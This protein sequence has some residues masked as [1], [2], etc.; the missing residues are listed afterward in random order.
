MGTHMKTTVEISDALLDA[1]KATAARRGTTLR[2]L[3]EEGLR[4]V[5]DDGA[6]GERFTLPDASVTG[7]GLSPGIEEGSWEAVRS[8]IYEGRGG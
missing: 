2:T 4:R 5:L 3:L 7:R 6:A 8:L 1:A